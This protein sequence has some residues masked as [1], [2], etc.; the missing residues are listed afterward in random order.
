MAK[1]LS[2]AGGT[3]KIAAGGNTRMAHDKISKIK[4]LAIT[5]Y[6]TQKAHSTL[7]MV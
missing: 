5:L 3:V 4:V 1:W 2:L 7:D 6:R